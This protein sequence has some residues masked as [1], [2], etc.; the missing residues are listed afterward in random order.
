MRGIDL[1]LADMGRV[2]MH[3]CDL[4]DAHMKLCSLGMATLP[5][6]DMRKADMVRVH[7]EQACVTTCD[8]RG[9]SLTSAY[10]VWAGGF[11]QMGMGNRARARPRRPV[12]NPA[13]FRLGPEC[14]PPCTTCLPC[15][16]AM[17]I[18]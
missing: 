3:Q 1:T 13:G 15:M 16:P 10:M 9:V 8:V 2:E 12:Y 11:R 14:T 5:Q 7:M 6:C 18:S 17:R 4:R